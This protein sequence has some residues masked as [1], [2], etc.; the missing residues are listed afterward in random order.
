MSLNTV[1]SVLNMP[2]SDVMESQTAKKLNRGL[3]VAAVT[4]LPCAAI[5]AIV[6]TLVLPGIGTAAGIELS[7]PI[8][9]EIGMDAGLATA[10]L[11][12]GSI[13]YNA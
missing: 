8:S 13:G 5:G 1:K 7:I 4:A 3:G 12:G 6:G 10:F 2:L 9:T 11:G